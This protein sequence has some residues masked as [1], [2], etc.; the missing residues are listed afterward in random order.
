MLADRTPWDN[1]A[2]GRPEAAPGS[3]LTPRDAFEVLDDLIGEQPFRAM[4]ST[5]AGQQVRV[6]DGACDSRR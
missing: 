3:A 6:V 4:H 2:L 1:R 5:L